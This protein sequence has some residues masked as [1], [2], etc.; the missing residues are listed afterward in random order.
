[1][2]CCSCSS[3]GVVGSKKMMPTVTTANT[4]CAGSNLAFTCLAGWLASVAWAA[5]GLDETGLGW[6]VLG[7]WLL[8]GLL[9]D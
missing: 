7:S 5:I 2:V 9:H 8:A 3:T 6:A 4:G 1:M